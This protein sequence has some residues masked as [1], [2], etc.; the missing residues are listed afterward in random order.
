MNTAAQELWLF[1]RQYPQGRGEAFLESA[2]PVWATQYARV[3]VMPMF[4]GPGHVEL[5]QGVEEQR[6]WQGPEAFRPLGWF[7]SAM[8]AGSLVRSMKQRGGGRIGSIA[9]VRE[10]SNHVRQLMHKANIVMD[11]LMPLYD[12]H[13]VAL[14]CTWMEDWVTVLALVKQRYP[15]LRLTTMAHGWDLFQERRRSCRIPF[16]D[17]QMRAVDQVLCISEDGARYL[18]SAYPEASDRITYAH[19]GT[20]DHGPAPWTPSGTLRLVT[21]AYLRPPKRLDLLATALR[22]VTC[23]V[24]WTHFGDGEDRAE[25][26][27][28]IAMLP[29]TIS[30]ELKGTVGNVELMHWYRDHPV[31]LFVHFSDHE[32]VPV[33]LMEAASFGVPLMANHVG[34]VAEVVTPAS[35]LL[36]DPAPE[37]ARI[38][39]RLNAFLGSEM[40][41]V[42]FRKGVRHF[43]EQRFHAGRNAL[44]ILE[45]LDLHGKN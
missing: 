34:G 38:A 22:E 33:S 11:R 19:L 41:T 13:R 40:A 9:Q 30:V 20:T 3:R 24:Q 36:L 23:P 6:L 28:A 8:S 29:T 18:R 42:A 37:P 43:W 16:R 21:C 10:G 25:L 35:G 32:G 2:L 44:A 7:D 31:D 45:K 14:V 12:P 39:D 4:E 5:P 1:T 27:R 17:L 26:E 15:Q